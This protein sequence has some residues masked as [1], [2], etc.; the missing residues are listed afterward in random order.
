MAR[1]KSSLLD[2]LVEIAESL[3][4]W[5]GVILAIGS[6]IIFHRFS[7]MEISH[8]GGVKD[9]GGIVFQQLAKTLSTIFQYLFPLAFGAGAL[10]S[11]IKQI[12]REHIYS[13]QASINT[14]RELDWREFEGLIGEAF[15]KQGYQVTQTGDGADGGIDLIL[16]KE[17]RKILVQC[18]HWKKKKVGVKEARELNGIVSAKDANGGILITS[19]AFTEE[20]LAFAKDS[21]IELI[22]G[23][24]LGR[25]I[26]H[27]GLREAIS[28]PAPTIPAC[29]RCGSQMVIRTAKKGLNVGTRFWGC[30]TYPR[31]KG[32]IN[33]N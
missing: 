31:C 9:F 5:M 21:Y 11:G 32:T 25:L 19:G 28:M 8:A 4:W 3:P 33:I 18:K 10:S 13:K 16:Y 12:R 23:N 6:Y 7:L 1:R 26:P 15:R 20:T 14:I 22:D 24:D 29:P 30:T 17:G 27:I 2:D